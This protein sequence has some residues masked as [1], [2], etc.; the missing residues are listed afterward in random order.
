VI[1]VGDIHGEV[2]GFAAILE[3]VRLIDKQRRW[4][5]G[6]ATLIQTGDITDRG[7]KVRDALDLLMKLEQE[8]AAAGGRVIALLGNHEVMNML[9]ELRDVAPATYASFADGKSEARRLAA[10]EAHVKLA[11]A[12]ATQLLGLPPAYKPGTQEVWMAQHPL[13]YVEYREAFGPQGRYGKWLRGRQAVA[14]VSGTIFMHAG[15]HPPSAPRRLEEINERVRR[16]LRA[17][18]NAVK[19]LIGRRVVLPTF[20]LQEMVD[21]AKTDYDLVSQI[22]KRSSGVPQ[23]DGT[24]GANPFDLAYLRDL[25]NF[26]TLGTWD[27]FQPDGPL[28]FRGFAM[29]SSEEGHEA[30]AR[31]LEMYGAEHFAVGHTVPATLR[32]S[33]R[34]GSR[35]ILLDTGMLSSVYK[36]GR[37][38]AL[39]I[40]D[41][42]YTAYYLDGEAVL[43]ES[44]KREAAGVP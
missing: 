16:E 7:P 11:A 20:T 33:P 44:G 2:D 30:T 31:L 14:L 24:A 5:G 19:L 22:V 28:W 27:I 17:F 1:A 37:P 41:G 6:R 38:S 29:W 25:E 40:L 34:F 36:G 12:R 13:G 10:Y 39:E 26:L 23:A 21:A 9:G 3:R 42:K 4:V 18:D 15:I 43:I 32:I 8:A 35:V